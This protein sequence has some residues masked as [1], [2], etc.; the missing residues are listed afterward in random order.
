MARRAVVDTHAL[1][2]FL[3]G[4]S[5]LGANARAVLDDPESTLY[6]PLIAL[7]EAC[8][9][10]EK[11]R[12]PGIPSVA[13]LLA[14]VDAD[15]R[16]VVVPLDRAILDGSL[17]LTPIVEMHDRLIVAT[18][19]YLCDQDDPIALLTVDGNITGSGLVST[20]W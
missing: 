13:V 11:G 4:S 17:G 20:I 5:K 1:I 8:W 10:V 12:A 7:A 19:L 15:A 9:I 3:I 6:L 2:W 18:A 14:A 16:F